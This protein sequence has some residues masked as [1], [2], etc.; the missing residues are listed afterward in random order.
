MKRLTLWRI[1]RIIKDV[2]VGII[3]MSTIIAVIVIAGVAVGLFL[4]FEKVF[5]QE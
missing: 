3:T 4:F 1:A 2:I 5:K